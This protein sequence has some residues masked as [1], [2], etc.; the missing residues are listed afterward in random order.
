MT[1]PRAHLVDSENGGF[2][3]CIS[4]CVRRGWL[5]GNDLV[6]GQSYEHRKDWVE[7]RLL[8][9]SEVFAV[10]L[11]GYA[12]MSNHY[13]AVLARISHQVCAGSL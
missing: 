3:H 8:K 1:Y 4:R 12:V 7:S 11:Y 13:H 6:S 10:N 9:L 2:Y 5:C